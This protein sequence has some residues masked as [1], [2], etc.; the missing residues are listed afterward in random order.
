MDPCDDA[1]VWMLLWG[2][3]Q[4][5]RSSDLYFI[6][7]FRVQQ[8]NT[9]TLKELLYIPLTFQQETEKK[10]HHEHKLPKEKNQGLTEMC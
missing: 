10:N 9:L 1:S 4:S 2:P 7:F 8:Q 5:L 6:F 3:Q